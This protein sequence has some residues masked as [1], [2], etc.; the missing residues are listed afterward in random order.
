M[1]IS[2][3]ELALLRTNVR[4]VGFACVENAIDEPLLESL[5]EESSIQRRNARRVTES[6][7]V[8]YRGYLAD[9]GNLASTFLTGRPIA[10][11]LRSVFNKSFVLV[12]DSSCSTY[13]EAGDF[14][15]PHRDG[16]DDCEVTVLIY[17]DASSP[18]LNSPQSGLVLQV[19][20]GDA[21][22]PGEVKAAIKTQSGSLIVG[23]GSR[24]WHGRPPLIE[25][26]RVALLT[27]CYS[28]QSSP[29]DA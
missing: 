25:D 5:R 9:L 22:E 16:A 12:K 15:S 10:G 8:S 27:A 4:E 18:N 1:N 3:R 13:F 14:L 2:K 21:D 29:F 7:L 11:L 19:Y 28:S 24:I 23:Q 20:E 6:G 26:E 17:L